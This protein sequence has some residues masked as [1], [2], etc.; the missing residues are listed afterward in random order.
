MNLLKNLAIL[1]ENGPDGVAKMAV[2]AMN[3]DFTEDAQATHEF[4]VFASCT[5]D[6]QGRVRIEY[7][8]FAVSSHFSNDVEELGSVVVYILNGEVVA[9]FSM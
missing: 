3:L 5:V 8:N 2:A 6:S 1:T 7:N 9:P 4:S